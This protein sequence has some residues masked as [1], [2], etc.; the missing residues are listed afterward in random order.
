[1]PI[2]ICSFFIYFILRGVLLLLIK[3]HKFDV[4]TYEEQKVLSLY[5]LVQKTMTFGN[6]I[7]AHTCDIAI[8]LSAIFESQRPGFK[9]MHCVF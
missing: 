1:M 8:L 4:S 9:N 3:I 6:S 7:T 5:R 2:Y